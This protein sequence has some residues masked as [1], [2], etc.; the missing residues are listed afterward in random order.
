MVQYERSKI[1]ATEEARILQIIDRPRVPED[2]EPRKA[3]QNT[4]IGGV[5]GLLF[6]VM[7]AFF[8]EYISKNK[9]LLFLKKT[10][11]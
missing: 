4:M 1:E 5:V 2:P 7:G 10:I 6:T 11:P 3:I 8:T 9:D